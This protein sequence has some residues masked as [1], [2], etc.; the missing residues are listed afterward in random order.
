M[1]RVL[2]WVTIGVLFGHLVTDAHK[3]AWVHKFIVALS[4]WWVILYLVD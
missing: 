1:I 4:F 3:S 2:L